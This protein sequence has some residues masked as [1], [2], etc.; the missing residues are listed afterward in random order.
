[1]DVV[2]DVGG[3]IEGQVWKTDEECICR[4]VTCMELYRLIYKCA[5]LAVP[6]SSL[7]L[8]HTQYNG[9]RYLSQ[10]QAL[11]KPFF[12]FGQMY[13]YKRTD[14]TDTTLKPWLCERH[15]QQ[16]ATLTSLRTEFEHHRSRLIVVR[17]E[18][19]R[20]QIEYMGKTTEEVLQIMD[21]GVTRLGPMTWK[22]V[23]QL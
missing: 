14:F 17:E 20:A 15:V 18:K 16:V 6:G 12:L 11:N 3:L 19:D 2:P 22:S 8:N 4:N 21:N 5:C 13:R 9:F 7:Y 23:S 1:M 10:R